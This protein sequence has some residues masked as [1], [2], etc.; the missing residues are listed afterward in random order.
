[1]AEQNTE[2]KENALTEE[3]LD[4]LD[5]NLLEIELLYKSRC[6]QAPWGGNVVVREIEKKDA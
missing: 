5:K 6:V 1:M 4:Q 3:E 2:N